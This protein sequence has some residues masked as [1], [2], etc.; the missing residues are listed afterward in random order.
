MLYCDTVEAIHKPPEI[1][2]SS[3]EKA[4]LK[5][6]K[7]ASS[8]KEKKLFLQDRSFSSTIILV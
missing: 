3:K 6:K 4:L 7:N 8:E 5:K 2:F 1:Y